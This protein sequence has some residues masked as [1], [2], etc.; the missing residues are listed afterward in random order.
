FDHG[1]AGTE[2]IPHTHRYDFDTR[3]IQGGV[4]EVRFEE[5]S[6]GRVEHAY[7]QLEYHCIADG[8]DGFRHRAMA[9]L[10]EESANTFT[11]GET[12]R[13]RAHRDIHTLRYVKPKTILL[14][15]QYADIQPS[16]TF[17][18]SRVG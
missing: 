17:A 13:N 1:G 10:R 4:T 15:T 8:G 16:T 5:V 2:A 18:W 9:M 3:V 14:L 6:T 11:Y 12:Y 7:Q